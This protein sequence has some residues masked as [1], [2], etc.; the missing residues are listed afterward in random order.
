MKTIFCS[1]CAII[2]ILLAQIAQAQIPSKPNATDSAGQRHGDWIILY[3]EHWEQ[4][5]DTAQVAYYRLINYLH[6]KPNGLVTDYFRNGEKQMEATLYT[7][8]PETYNGLRIIYKNGLKQQ[9]EM[10]DAGELDPDATIQLNEQRIK[11]FENI[12]DVAHQK[13]Y[14]GISLELAR[15]YLWNEEYTPAY[16]YI[17]QSLQTLKKLKL[18]QTAQYADALYVLGDIYH[19]QN[20]FEDATATYEKM[21]ALRDKISQHKEQQYTKTLNDIA[22]SFIEYGYYD[23]AEKLLLKSIDIAKKDLNQNQRDY[24]VS[25]NELGKLYSKTGQ[26]EK[27]DPILRK[28]T[29]L[30]AKVYGK[31]SSEYASAL[32]N[33]AIM[34]KKIGSNQKAYECFEKILDIR[35]QNSGEGSFAYAVPLNSFALLLSDMGLY[36]S[37]EIALNKVKEIVALKL[38][39]DHRHYINTL[40]NIGYNHFKKGNYQQ[41]HDIFVR[42]SDFWKKNIGKNSP[43]YLSSLN[44]Q[45][46]ALKYLNQFK[47]SRKKLLQAH[48]MEKEVLGIYHP[49]YGKNTLHIAELYTLMGK[50]K[51]AIPYYLEVIDNLQAQIERYFPI[52]SETEKIE[53]YNSKKETIEHFYSFIIQNANQNPELLGSMMDLQLTFKGIL[54]NTYTKWFQRIKQSGDS[55]LI[56]QLDN[57]QS[58]VLALGKYYTM[59]QQQLSDLNINLAAY[60]NKVEVLEK[61]LS[62]NLKDK[63]GINLFDKISYQNI[64]AKLNDDQVA[65]DILRLNKK[66]FTTKKHDGTISYI[67]LIISKDKKYPT[68]VRIPNGDQLEKKQINF[69]RNSAIHRFEDTASYQHFWKPIAQ[70]L[71][72]K[73]KV[74]IALDGV[75]NLISLYTLYDPEQKEYLIDQI[76]LELTTNLRDLL[77]KTAIDKEG[78]QTIKLIGNPNFSETKLERLRRIQPEQA[79]NYTST[80]KSEELLD[81]FRIEQLPNAEVETQEI[82]HLFDQKQWKTQ[83]YIGNDAYEEVIKTP[84]KQPRI[85]HIATHGYFDENAL[86]INSAAN[87]RMLKSGLLLSG[88]SYAIQDAVISRNVD[89]V[90]A[91]IK[92]EDGLLTAYEVMNQN[93]EGTDLVVLSACETARGDVVNGEGVYGLQRAFKVA[94]A[95]GLIMSQWPVSD[96]TTRLMVKTLYQNFLN[97]DELHEAFKKAQLTVK[98]LFPEPYYWGAFIFIED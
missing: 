28:V 34:L 72:G 66:T 50:T 54:L 27:A 51:K 43:Q 88:A 84:T 42:C 5:S 56:N 86:H 92:V 63:Y 25:M 71:K 8:N 57:Y 64:Q 82:S 58:E 91:D 9:V 11:D 20:Q 79:A 24:V 40:N 17:N 81:F 80:A 1:Y 47:K 59:T 83:L 69:Y 68:L 61:K 97:G 96:A 4:I 7:E 48:K 44:N 3:D 33:Y 77:Q 31:S 18:E 93:F 74:S 36:D 23:K 89:D 30:S 39:E 87:H 46:E 14:A 78:E 67:A 52:L 53:F 32:N 26:F 15:L 90:L 29:E 70:H 41:A 65:I 37:A 16:K 76:D 2:I 21:L 13:V 10:F 38:G 6:G 35:E 75:Y 98:K 62:K 49:N 85:W 12:Q 45:G 60:E 19:M 73:K 95:K 22:Y 94:G 55:A